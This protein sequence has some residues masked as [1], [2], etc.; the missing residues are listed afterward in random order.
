MTDRRVAHSTQTKKSIKFYSEKVKERH[1][2]RNLEL[3]NLKHV[4]Y[5]MSLWTFTCFVQMAQCVENT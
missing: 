4:P 1:K 2:R 3:I 5:E